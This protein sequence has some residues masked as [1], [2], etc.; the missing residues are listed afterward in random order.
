MLGSDIKA[1]F[2]EDPLFSGVFLGV[3]AAD[4]VS[5]LFIKER[6]AAVINTD[7]I[8]GEGKHWWCILR[9]H[10]KLEYFD[11]LGVSSAEVEKRLGQRCY[12]NDSPVQSDHSALCGQFCIYFVR[13]SKVTLKQ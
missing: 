3:F 8:D 5:G 2:E 12:F 7:S 9:L 1:F 4:Q 6:T 11:P 13:L 10:G